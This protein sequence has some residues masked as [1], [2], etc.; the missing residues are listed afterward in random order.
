MVLEILSQG[1]CFWRA[2]HT[3]NE[4]EGLS[5]EKRFQKVTTDPS[6]TFKRNYHDTQFILAQYT[7]LQIL[8]NFSEDITKGS[9]FGVA[10]WETLSKT[11]CRANPSQNSNED[12]KNVQVDFCCVLGW[13][14]SS[15]TYCAADPCPN[16][17]EGH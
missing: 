16:F 4:L 17:K 6:L 5:H 3:Q 8:P 10:G 2:C 9:F 11:Y 7:V 1:K 12:I 13:E 14:T 15:K